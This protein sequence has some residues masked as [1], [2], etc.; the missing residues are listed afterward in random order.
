M[1]GTVLVATPTKLQVPSARSGQ[2]LRFAQDDM[3]QEPGTGLRTC[4]AP[5]RE[6]MQRKN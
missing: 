2:A 4:D 1:W 3:L 6:A 5:M